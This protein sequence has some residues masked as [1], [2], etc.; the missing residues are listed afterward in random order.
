MLLHGDLMPGNL[1]VRDGRLAAVIDF[2]AA[3]F[4]D[5]AVDLMPAWHLLPAGAR[6][7]FRDAL[8][9]DDALWQRGIGWALVQAIVALPYYQQ[10]NPGMAATAT[11]TLNA[12]LAD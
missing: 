4:G 1:L 11:F 8:G 2:G 10:T 6:G 9:A 12:L 5:P 7:V 3:T